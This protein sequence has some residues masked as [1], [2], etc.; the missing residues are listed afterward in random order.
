[1]FCFNSGQGSIV[2]EPLG[3]G[4]LSFG[5][6]KN[7]PNFFPGGSDFPF[8]VHVGQCHVS[9]FRSVLKKSEAEAVLFMYKRKKKNLHWQVT[10]L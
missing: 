5:V 4:E 10:S 9:L 3:R 2:A 8:S 6:S 1:M 7:K